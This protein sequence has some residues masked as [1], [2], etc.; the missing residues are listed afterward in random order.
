MTPP[1]RRKHKEP[2]LFDGWTERKTRVAVYDRSNGACERCDAAVAID[3]HHR[4]NR[5]QSGKWHPANIMHLC[6]LCHVEITSEPKKS[7]QAGWTVPE[8]ENPADVP[9]V[10]RGRR[11]LLNDRC[12]V[13]FISDAQSA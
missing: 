8:R 1:I 3:M 4:K 9:V 7:T 5:S 13:V 2:I 11:A 10:Y 6:R 12:N